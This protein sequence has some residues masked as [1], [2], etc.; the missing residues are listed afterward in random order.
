M[1][2][3]KGLSTGILFLAASVFW[4][5][6]CSRKNSELS[7]GAPLEKTHFTEELVVGISP[8]DLERYQPDLRMVAYW[9]AGRVEV[10]VKN[11]SGRA[12]NLGPDNFAVI[13]PSAGARIV[14]F[15]TDQ[16]KAMFPTTV[17]A[18]NIEASGWFQFRQLGNLE[19]GFLIFNHSD[20]AVR[21]SRCRIE[22]KIKSP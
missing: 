4:A 7:G 1:F 18:D 3:R 21:P 10:R 11:R 19:G 8:E 16:A 6:G 20:P 5:S 12:I 14:P 2:P 17:L 9:T 22:V 15:K 13:A